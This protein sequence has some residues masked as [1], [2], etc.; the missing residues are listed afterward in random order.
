MSARKIFTLAIEAFQR[1]CP[2][3]QVLSL[4]AMFLSV[5]LSAVYV[6]LYAPLKLIVIFFALGF[7][8]WQSQHVSSLSHHSSS[9]PP[10]RLSS[11]L[12]VS[13]IEQ[14]TLPAYAPKAPILVPC[15]VSVELA[16][17]ST[18]IS[19]VLSVSTSQSSPTVSPSAAPSLS[20][21]SAV[22][23]KSPLS[24]APVYQARCSS[25][26]PC[27]GSPEALLFDKMDV[28]ISYNGLGVVS[29]GIE[30]SVQAA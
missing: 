1:C 3:F 20:S 13:T 8:V 7:V 21:H 9:E 15:V 2:E 17:G 18:A 29:A 23:S 19:S 6:A 28:R 30:G 24:V 26:M 27:P 11:A 14:E 4:M 12:S 25:V 16:S 10:S 22:S 5:L